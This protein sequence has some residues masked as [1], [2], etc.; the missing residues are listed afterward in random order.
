MPSHP[1]SDSPLPPALQAPGDVSLP[2][3][4]EVRESVTSLLLD[5]ADGDAAAA[6][7]LFPLIYDE[8]RRVAHRQLRAER[9]GHTLC[10]TAL[11]HEAYLRLVV[12]TRAKWEHRP[13]FFAIAAQA[14]RRVLVDHARRFRAAKRGGG[15]ERL[16]LDDADIPVAER[17][18]LLVALDDALRQLAELS[19]RLAQVVE[20]RFFG[21]MTEA[22]TAAA[23]G[24]TERTVRRDWVKAKGWL[25]TEVAGVA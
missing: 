7:A 11:V 22:E 1:R 9:A 23:L 24:V 20:C 16:S 3:A 21:G 12:Q 17:A 15:M 2:T 13:Q 10:T 25:A 6:D 14:M 18:E 5:L 8:L 19:P 4:S